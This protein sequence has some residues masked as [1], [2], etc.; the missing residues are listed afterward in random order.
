[1][2]IFNIKL[3]LSLLNH[4]IEEEK[5]YAETD[6]R[7]VAG[8]LIDARYCEESS[9]SVDDLRV[10]FDALYYPEPELN[11]VPRHIYGINVFYES[12][13]CFSDKEGCKSFMTKMKKYINSDKLINTIDM[14]VINA[15]KMRERRKKYKYE[16][17]TL[18]FKDEL[19]QYRLIISGHNT[20]PTFK[21]SLYGVAGYGLMYLGS[22]QG[23]EDLQWK[24]MDLFYDAQF[25]IDCKEIKFICKDL[26]RLYRYTSTYGEGFGVTNCYNPVCKSYSLEDPTDNNKFILR[27]E[28]STTIV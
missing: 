10:D 16:E 21:F 20:P 17:L 11:S 15:Y 3:E 22:I 7:N 23:F 18:E 26:A 28:V 6:L 13:M 19:Y 9:N 4:N 12:D 24:L 1:M 25:I 2:E 27:L 5:T 14:L 8:T